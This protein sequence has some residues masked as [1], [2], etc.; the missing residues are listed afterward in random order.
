MNRI[1]IWDVQI[2]SSVIAIWQAYMIPPIPL[3]PFIILLLVL[4]LSPPFSSA[5]ADDCS[6]YLDYE[7]VTAKVSLIDTTI[8]RL[9][10]LSHQTLLPFPFFSIHFFF[11]PNHL[12]QSFVYRLFQPSD[13]LEHFVML[14]RGSSDIAAREGPSIQ[15]TATRETGTAAR[16]DRPGWMATKPKG[17]Q[18]LLG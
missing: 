7:F 8:A 15:N 4:P 11:S 13:L 6:T 5:Y 1:C 12:L 9:I 17:S 18:R 10:N 2:Y 3:F 14:V 16:G